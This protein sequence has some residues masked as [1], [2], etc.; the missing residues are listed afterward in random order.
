MKEKTKKIEGECKATLEIL[1]HEIQQCK[2]IDAVHQL[3][4]CWIKPNDLHPERVQT[5]K[6]DKEGVI[7][8]VV[9]FSEPKLSNKKA[10]ILNII[11]F[12]KPRKKGGDAN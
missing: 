1:I 9:K 2:D 10:L 5:I 4:D 7:L 12:F 8:S 3:L 11:Q 6:L